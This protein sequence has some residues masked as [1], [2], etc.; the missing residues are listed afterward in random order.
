M[1]KKMETVTI[2]LQDSGLPATTLQRFTIEMELRDGLLQ[3]DQFLGF[4]YQLLK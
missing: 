1:E 2:N 3:G 4:K